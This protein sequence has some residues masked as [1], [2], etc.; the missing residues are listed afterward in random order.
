MWWLLALV[1]MFFSFRQWMVWKRKQNEKNQL[2]VAPAQSEQR[3]CRICNAETTP[4]LPTCWKCSQY[5]EPE[6]DPSLETGPNSAAGKRYHDGKIARGE[7]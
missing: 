6:H 5:K 1:L 4:A 7:Y 2:S 3:Y